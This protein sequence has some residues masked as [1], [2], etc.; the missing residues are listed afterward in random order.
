[1]EQHKTTSAK[2]HEAVERFEQVIN[3]ITEVFWLTNVLKNEMAYISPGYERIWGRKCEDLYRDPQSW[4]SAVHP[5]DREAV[6]RR[7]RTEQAS[8]EY[9]V[10]YRIIRPDG[11]VRWIRDRAFPVRNQQG[12][13]YRVAGIAED[14]TERKRTRETLQMQAALLENMAE[15]VVVTDK[16]GLIVQ[17]NPAGERIWGYE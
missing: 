15:G 16:E 2:L 13:V 11:A 7:A 1:V 14:I 4:L 5:E 3:D 12:E 17:M 6:E 8:G 9:N 10:E